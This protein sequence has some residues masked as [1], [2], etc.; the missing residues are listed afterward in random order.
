MIAAAL[1][2]AAAAPSSTDDVVYACEYFTT[3]AQMSDGWVHSVD[4]RA[5]R[6]GNANWVIERAGEPP[7]QAQESQGNVGD[8]LR[9]VKLGWQDSRMAKKTA[10]VSYADVTL[11]D[12]MKVAWLTF[13]QPSFGKAPAYFC[14]T[15]GN[16]K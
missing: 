5:V 6:H 14:Q 11:P 8:T 10:Y 16:A 2:A 12:N 9:T 7:I 4:L 1:L 3:D 13:D 15:R